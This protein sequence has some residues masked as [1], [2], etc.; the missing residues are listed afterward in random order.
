MLFP[1]HRRPLHFLLPPP[2]LLL[3]LHSFQNWFKCPLFGNPSLAPIFTPKSQP[4][5][6]DSPWAWTGHAHTSI[7]A[8]ITQWLVIYLHFQLPWETVG[9]FKTGSIECLFCNKYPIQS[10]GAR[11]LQLDRFGFQSPCSRLCAMRLW[12]NHVTYLCIHFFISTMWIISFFRG[13]VVRNQW[14]D[15]CR[16]KLRKIVNIKLVLTKCQFSYLINISSINKNIYMDIYSAKLING[17]DLS[18]T[19]DSEGKDYQEQVCPR[20]FRRSWAS[21]W[22]SV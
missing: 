10:L 20:S 5:S 22:C 18:C 11:A 1:L 8:L 7:P 4:L 15:I 9:F 19:R 2:N 14:G 13:W 3:T 12:L 16:R 21:S 17:S 6:L